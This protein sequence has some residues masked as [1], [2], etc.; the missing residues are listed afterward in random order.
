MDKMH[1][2]DIYKSCFAAFGKYLI[3]G[4]RAF[5]INA[6]AI[7]HQLTPANGWPDGVYSTLE[8]FMQKEYNLGTHQ[9]RFTHSTCTYF[10][11]SYA[12]LYLKLGTKEARRIIGSEADKSKACNILRESEAWNTF[13]AAQKSAN[14]YNSSWRK[15][16]SG[17]N[18]SG[19]LRQIRES[20]WPIEKKQ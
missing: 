17:E 12:S 9:I 16:K 11:S 1:I 13:K 7:L 8:Q 4:G 18:K 3:D 20:L 14:V 10:H 6:T 15:L 2:N 19:L 5:L